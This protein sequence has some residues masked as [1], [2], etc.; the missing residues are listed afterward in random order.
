MLGYDELG[1]AAA[2]QWED[3][4][5]QSPGEQVNFLEIAG[6]DNRHRGGDGSIAR[7][8][9][10]VILDQMSGE[11]LDAGRRILRVLGNIDAR[12]RP[13]RKLCQEVGFVCLG[14]AY[15]DNDYLEEWVYVSE[16]GRSTQT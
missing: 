16:L 11:A 12:N 10:T 7:E 5:E 2:F 3:L 4:G 14:R 13:S 6:V 1:I 8:M 15:S 9:A